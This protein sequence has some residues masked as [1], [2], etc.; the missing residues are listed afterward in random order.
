MLWV[1]PDKPTEWY[2]FISFVA[3]PIIAVILG[4]VFIKILSRR[5]K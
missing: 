3:S 1:F 4:I 2:G 5:K